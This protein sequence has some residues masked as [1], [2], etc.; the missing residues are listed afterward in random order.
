[1]L[2]TFAPWV[3]GGDCGRRTRTKEGRGR[4]KG[5]AS[6]SASPLGENKTPFPTMISYPPHGRGKEGKGLK[7]TPIR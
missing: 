6:A 1:M 7:R 3:K 4:G 2:Y 5:R